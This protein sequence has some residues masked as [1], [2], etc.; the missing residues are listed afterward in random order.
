MNGNLMKAPLTQAL[1][2]TVTSCPLCF[3]Y[4]STHWTVG[5]DILHGLTDLPFEYV[6][7]N[8]C[9]LIYARER[10]PAEL[11][12]SYYPEEYDPYKNSDEIERQL[13]KVDSP[14]IQDYVRKNSSNAKLHKKLKKWLSRIFPDHLE[15]F[16]SSLLFRQKEGN[17]TLLDFGCGSDSY[18]NLARKAGW[19]TIGMDFSEKAILSVQS[20]GHKAILYQ[21]EDAWNEI[22][23]DSI[24]LIRMNHVIEH[25]FEPR[26]LLAQLRSK[27]KSNGILYLSTPNAGGYSATKYKNHWRGLECPR[28]VILY[29]PSTLTTLL[30]E[31]S[32]S[33]IKIIHEENP[34]DAIRSKAYSAFAETPIASEEIERLPNKRNLF[35]RSSLYSKLNAI[36]RKGDRIH[37][38]CTKN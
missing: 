37:A 13:P 9:T 20:S 30:K 35:L 17:K 36:I 12:G 5:H 26:K 18:L 16:L 33:D 27:L 10:I 28:H 38:Y 31:S 8:N 6:R 24:D 22:N 25:I 11:I 15:P 2:E 14:E 23:N 3:S 34:K 19:S 29:S 1:L 4:D 32:F 7:C 21:S